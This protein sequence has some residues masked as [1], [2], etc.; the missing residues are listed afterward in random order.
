M[1][2][3]RHETQQPVREQAAEATRFEELA[4]SP[5]HE[6]AEAPKVKRQ[7]V[8]TFNPPSYV[9]PSAQ[10]MEVEAETPGEAIEIWK[11]ATG[12]TGATAVPP[13]VAELAPAA[14]A[15]QGDEGEATGESEPAADGD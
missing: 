8:V 5:R 15:P 13:Q 12:F 3:K 2:R 4:D 11:Q 14:P 7:F 9:G 10:R 6:A 1:T